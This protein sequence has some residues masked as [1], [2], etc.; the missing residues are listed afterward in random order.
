MKMSER[1]RDYVKALRIGDSVVF[2]DNQ[3][4]YKGVVRSIIDGKIQLT[5]TDIVFSQDTSYAIGDEDDMPPRIMYPTQELSEKLRKH[6]E[7]RGSRDAFAALFDQD[8][9]L[10]DRFLRSAWS[11][12]CRARDGEFPEGRFQR[13][14]YLSEIR[15]MLD[16]DLHYE[17]PITKVREMV[18]EGKDLGI[19]I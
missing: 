11:S 12:L 16:D 10:P 2:Q 13:Y 19:N 4:F 7:I 15:E 18:N 9:G 6:E 3:E 14:E 17:I 8:T 5:G 1:V